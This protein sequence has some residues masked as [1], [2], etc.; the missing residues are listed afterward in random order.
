[1]ALRDHPHP[2]EETMHIHTANAA[3]NADL[4]PD[5]RRR[6]LVAIAERR[7]VLT[8]ELTD[9]DAI[10]AGHRAALAAAGEPTGTTSH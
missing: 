9:L 3:Q 2:Q 7:A 4:T 10:E 1:M 8:A 6:A 5:D